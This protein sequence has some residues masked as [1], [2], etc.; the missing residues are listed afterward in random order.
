MNTWYTAD[1]HFFHANII[2]HCHRPFAS[3]GEMN[4]TLIERWNERVAPGDIV[5]VLGDFAWGVGRKRLEDLVTILKGRKR[6]VPGNHDRKIA[7]MLRGGFIDV[8]ES[9]VISKDIV[10]C[11]YP[12]A[13]WP[14][15][16]HGTLMLHGHCHGT[17][18]PR[19]RRVDVGVDAWDF[20]PV[21]LDEIENKE[22]AW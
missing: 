21:S 4:A 13:S 19:D 8:S 12:L 11:H 6:I 14:R 1:T 2:R 7:R 20:R 9:L 18:P 10:L 15:M 22:N 16:R 5:Y 3:V 17:L